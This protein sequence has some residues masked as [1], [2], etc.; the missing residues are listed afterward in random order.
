MY[1]CAALIL[2]SSSTDA[3]VLGG[4]EQQSA[5]GGCHRPIMRVHVLVSDPSDWARP[6]G[7]SGYRNRSSI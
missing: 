6:K 1:R 4:C 2:D 3:A 5:L 7:L